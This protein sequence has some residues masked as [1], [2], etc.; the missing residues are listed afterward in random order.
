MTMHAPRDREGSPAV[1]VRVA[2]SSMVVTAEADDPLAEAASTMAFEE[3]GSVV[4]LD[5][6]VFVGIV[7]EHDLVRAVAEGVD[8][9]RTA[10]RDYMTRDPV[11]VEPDDEVEH[12]IHQMVG[13]GARHLPVVT[14]GKVVG[15]LSARDLLALR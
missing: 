2:C 3:I 11:V 4:V 6:G 8:L 9:D 15:M 12:A 5:D 1:K 13:A 10:V 14:A 7:T